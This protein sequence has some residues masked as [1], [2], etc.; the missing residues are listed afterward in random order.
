MNCAE[1]LK[2]VSFKMVLGSS[3][4]HFFQQKNPQL[5][6]LRQKKLR[7]KMRVSRH[8]LICDTVRKWF[9][10]G[11]NQWKALVFVHLT[12][13]RKCEKIKANKTSKISLEFDAIWTLQNFCFEN[14]FFFKILCRSST[15]RHWIIKVDLKYWSYM[16]VKL[17]ETSFQFFSFSKSQN[18]CRLPM[19][20]AVTSCRSQSL[21]QSNPL[22][23][24]ILVY[25][26]FDLIFLPTTYSNT[27]APK[28]ELAFDLT[29]TFNY[30]T[31][32]M[33]YR[34]STDLGIQSW[35]QQ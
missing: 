35:D 12:V 28:M 34:E 4:H 25:A 9:K 8:L 15:K 6:F 14:V 30:Q 19:A 3:I 16:S 5:Q 20:V 31:S 13:H 1:L 29:K 33:E 17:P 10:M 26:T 27:H 21:R 22:C 18:Y 23:R 2:L 32:Q 24:H 11:L 7:Q